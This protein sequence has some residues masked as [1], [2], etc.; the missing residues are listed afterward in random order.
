MRIFQEWNPQFPKASAGEIIRFGWIALW[1]GSAIAVGVLVALLPWEAFGGPVVTLCLAVALA[2]TLALLDSTEEDRP[3]VARLFFLALGVH[4]AVICVFWWLD[5]GRQTYWLKD[6]RAYDQVGWA[7]AE[8]WRAGASMPSG[9]GPLAWLSEDTFPRIVGGV[10]FLVGHS[11]LSVLCIQSVLASSCV[12]L[13]YRLGSLV[14]GPVTA[15]LSGWIMIG[16]TGFLLFSIMILKD[17]AVLFLILL[18]FYGWFRIQETLDRAGARAQKILPL[19]FWSALAITALAGITSL[20]DYTAQIIA[21]AWLLGACHWLVRFSKKWKWAT[22]FAIVAA[23]IFALEWAAPGILNKQLPPTL[24]A[25]DSLLFSVVQPPPAGKISEQLQWIGVHPQD[26]ALYIASASASTLIAPF[27][28]IFPGTL[29]NAPNWNVYFIAYPGMWLWYAL[30]P[31]AFIGCIS[32]LRRTRGDVLPILFFIVAIFFL[33]VLLIPREVRHRDMLMP[34]ALILAAEGVMYG[35]R[36]AGLGL[37]IWVPLAGFMAW[38]LG[39]LIPYLALLIV[40]GFLFLALQARQQR[41][42][43]KIAR[44]GVE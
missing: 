6:A 14:L 7:W 30:L 31:F 19:I 20:R 41:R 44:G 40:A 21:G 17:V 26:F 5:G 37:C 38:K 22:V 8:A 9:L 43:Q 1:A 29:P 32:A 15:R 12:Y 27:A 18:A 16:Y 13:A 23:G 34:F 36:W 28:W 3:F 10:Y 2:L 33:V 39:M 4:L 42:N 25:P 11:P 35:R 24:I